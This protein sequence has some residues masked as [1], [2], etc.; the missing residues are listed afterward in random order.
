MKPVGLTDPR[1]GRFPYAAVQLRQDTLAGDHFSLVG[2]QTQLKWGE[3]ARVLRMIPGLEQAEFVRFGMVHRNTYINGPTVLRDTWQ[4]RTPRRPVLRRPGLGRRRL[5]R[6]GRVRADRRAQRRGAGAQAAAH[7]R[8]RARRRS[9][10]WRTTCRTPI[11]RTTS[12]RNITHGIMPPLD[13][14]P[15]DK[16]R[17]KA[18]I[19]ERAL[20]R[21]RGVAA[22]IARNR[23]VAGWTGA[24]I[25]MRR[26]LE[27]F[28]D[29]LR[30]N[31]NASDAYRPRLRI[32]HHAVSR[33]ASRP[34]RR[35]RIGELDAGG[36]RPA[37]VRAH[38]AELGRAGEAR[39]S[40]AR[41]LSALRTFVRYLRREGHIEHDPTALAVAPRREQTLP[42]HLTEHEMTRLLETAGRRAIRWAAA[43]ARSSNCS[44]RPGLRLSELES[45]DLENVDLQRAHG[46][47]DGQGRA[48]SGSC[49]SIRR[50]SG[51]CA[52]G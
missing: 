25:A 28:L 39:S 5:R 12:R 13:N 43:I 18:L 16:L 49:R 45:L 32:G 31:R 50:P 2:F 21:S 8:R 1:T 23:G 9:A 36:S 20:R 17:K 38:L 24:I 42:V 37:T 33:L 40:V 52:R 3:Q 22:R 15:R 10:R 44:T 46:A 7:A 26:M 30:F 6:I 4:T 27:A 29:Y 41:K 35:R 11:R 14:P 48:R 47:G 34:T 19:A 51:R